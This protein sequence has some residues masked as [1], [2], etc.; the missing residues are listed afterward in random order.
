MDLPQYWRERLEA[1]FGGGA[2]LL[3]SR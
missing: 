3:R 2:Q 1:R